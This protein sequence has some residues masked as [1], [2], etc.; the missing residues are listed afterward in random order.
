[1]WSFSLRIT[2]TV[3]SLLSTPTEIELPGLLLLFLQEN[4]NKQP[5]VSA[6]WRIIFSILGS[7]RIA[8]CALSLSKEMAMSLSQCINDRIKA[9]FQRDCSTL[10]QKEH[11]IDAAFKHTYPVKQHGRLWIHIPSWKPAYNER[12][13]LQSIVMRLAQCHVHNQQYNANY[14]DRVRVAEALIIFVMKA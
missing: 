10:G 7:N 12:L 6:A 13:T 4:L 14:P 11:R 1:M 3:L 5:S 2:L 8:R 9:A